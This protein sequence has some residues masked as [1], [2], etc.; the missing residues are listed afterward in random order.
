MRSM[1]LKECGR[2]IDT[3]S[4][5]NSPSYLSAARL[6]FQGSICSS[7]LGDF[8][9]SGPIR[10]SHLYS[11]CCRASGQQAYRIGSLI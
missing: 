11:E 9:P 2:P 7:A 6:C 3:K 8:D 4:M 10:S 1:G 5:L